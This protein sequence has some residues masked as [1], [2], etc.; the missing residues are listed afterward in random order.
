MSEEIPVIDA[1]IYMKKK[2]GWEEECNKVAQSF[3]KYGIVK[4]RDPRVNEH[5]N[6]LFIDMVEKYFD[7]T[8][9]KY[10]AGEKIADIRPELCY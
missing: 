7:E 9:Q 3:H 1:E 5:D 2:E 6:N 10:Y 4:F 8:S